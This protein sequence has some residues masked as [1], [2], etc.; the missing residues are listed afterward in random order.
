MPTSESPD[1]TQP[2]PVVNPAAPTAASSQ[3][4]EKSSGN[5]VLRFIGS[6]FTLLFRMGVLTGGAGLALVVGVAIAAIRP[7]EVDEPPV[8]ETI[9]QQVERFRR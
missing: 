5:P 8:L 4:A 9:V 6:L 1:T 2:T 3:T 7:A